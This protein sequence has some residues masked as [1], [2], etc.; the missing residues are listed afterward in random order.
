MPRGLNGEGM[1]FQN[2]TQRV[3][4]KEREQIR[5]EHAAY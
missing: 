2:V 5:K 3:K 4:K 1:H